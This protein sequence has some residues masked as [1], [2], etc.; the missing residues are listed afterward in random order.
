[1]GYRSVTSGSYNR[2]KGLRWQRDVRSYLREQGIP[3]V[4]PATEGTDGDHGDVVC[5]NVPVT[6][7]VKNLQNLAV[8]VN[9]SLS[10]AVQQAASNGH[11]YGWGVCR[12]RGKPAP[13]NALF[14]MEGWQAVNLLRDLQSLRHA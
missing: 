12:R 9:S 8:A 2:T 1:M 13:G 10:E 5:L 4:E 3:C 6:L 11:R 7:Q 14:V